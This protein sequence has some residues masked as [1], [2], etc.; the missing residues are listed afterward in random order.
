[1]A[2]DLAVKIATSGDRRS[3]ANANKLATEFMYECFLETKQKI[4]ANGGLIDDATQYNNLPTAQTLGELLDKVVF[5]GWLQ[6]HARRL[7]K[8]VAELRAK[9]KQQSI[10]SWRI[11]RALDEVTKAQVPSAS[12]S[13]FYDQHF[14]GLLPYIDGVQLD[15][16]QA[17]CY[18]QAARKDPELGKFEAQILPSNF[19][20][21]IAR[22]DLLSSQA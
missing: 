8:S 14:A 11:Y 7:L 1:M 19:Q 3:R 15:K 16:R 18:R 22:L 20:K 6:I 2:E 21:L 5:E 17:E 12:A 9:V 4:E 10:L 13:D